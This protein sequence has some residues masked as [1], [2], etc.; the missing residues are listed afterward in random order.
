MIALVLALAGLARG[1]TS[2]R[3]LLASGLQSQFSQ[4]PTEVSSPPTD[5]DEEACPQAD[6]ELST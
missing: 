5:R 2:H 1:M 4:L 6:A 3:G